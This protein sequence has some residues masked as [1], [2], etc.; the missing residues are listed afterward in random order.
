MADTKQI[1]ATVDTD[2]V[3]WIDKQPERKMISFSKM[4]GVLLSESRQKR[5]FKNKKEKSK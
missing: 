4:V 2:L 5:D 1:V 3:N